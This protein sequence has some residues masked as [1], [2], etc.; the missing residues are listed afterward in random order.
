MIGT[1]EAEA[2]VPV[3]IRGIAGDYGRPVQAVEFS[4]DGGSH[5]TRYDLAREPGAALGA[6][7]YWTFEYIFEQ[8]GSYDLL[9]RSVSPDG[10]VSPDA[11]HV[12]VAV[13]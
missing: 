3:T 10:R 13:R 1:I 4:L 7:A 12:P 5:W 2:G 8:P 11:A 9:V 6:N